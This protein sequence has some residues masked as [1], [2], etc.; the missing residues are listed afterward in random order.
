MRT[1][2]RA[3]IICAAFRCYNRAM[4]E[5]RKR[6]LR[7]YLVF[8]VK[9]IEMLDIGAVRQNAAAGSLSIQNPVGRRP[10]DFAD[11]LR[12]PH[13]S[14][15]ALLIDKNGMDVIKLWS[16]LFPSH[17]QEIKETWNRIKPAWDVI[18]TF[19]NRAGFHADKPK[20]FF[21]ARHEV[22]AQQQRI[23]EAIEDFQK[24]FRTILKAE[25]SE[26][27]DLPQAVDEFLDELEAEHHSSFNRQEFKR[28]L[29]IPDIPAAPSL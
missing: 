3:V 27:P 10:S 28:Y 21:K 23:R 29:M 19:R 9:A 17:K 5:M 22:I 13:L 16:D 18:R 8:R 14:W 26:L 1:V 4:T 2:H 15:F 25:A 7:E 6:A 11:S 20:L 24:L 12:T